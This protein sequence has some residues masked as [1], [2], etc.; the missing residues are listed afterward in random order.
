MVISCETYTI[1]DTPGSGIP[2]FSADLRAD[3]GKKINSVGIL[4]GA[5]SKRFMLTNP[6]NDISMG[7]VTKRGNYYDASQ[8]YIDSLMDLF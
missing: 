5:K 2:A 6:W 1:S 3:F 7:D 8:D 4:F